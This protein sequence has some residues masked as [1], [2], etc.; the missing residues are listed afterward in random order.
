MLKRIAGWLRS[1]RRVIWPEG[2]V[3][4]L[5][6]EL[7]ENGY[8]CVEC[9][10][11]LCLQRMKGQSGTVRCAY[12]YGGTAK[13][14]VTALKFDSVAD[15]AIVLGEAMAEEARQMHLPPDTLVTWVTMDK[16]RR[17]VRG[18]D[19]GQRL[20]Q[21]IADRLGLEARDLLERTRRVRTQLGLSGQARR[22]NLKGV[23][24]CRESLTGPV[25]I[26]DDVLTTGA[27]IREC[28]GAL[29]QGGATEIFAVT[30]TKA[31]GAFGYAFPEEDNDRKG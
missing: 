21:A 3:C 23:F 29:R 6:D 22:S 28:A 26:V 8:L 12:R 31:G 5:C 20:A 9:A 24:I 17:L 15:A 25:L 1:L 18:M 7:A 19:H 30:A 13:K 11:A 4:L 10:D 14:L 2:V 27:T 16:R